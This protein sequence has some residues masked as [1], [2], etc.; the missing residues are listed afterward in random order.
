MKITIL[1]DNPNSWI[2]HYVARLKVILGEASH[3]FTTKGMKKGDI[4]FIL[5][6]ENIIPPEIL[7]LHKYNVVIHPSDLPKGRGWSPLAW[8]IIEGKND[9]VFT[10]FEATEK[11]DAGHVYM[12]KT[13]RLEGNELN[14]EIK[15]LQ[16]LMVINMV[17]EI[18]SHIPKAQPQTGVATYYDKRTKEHSLLDVN[19]SIAEQFNLLRVV[20]NERYPA[21]FEY[22]GRRYILS[23]RHE[24]L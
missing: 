16:G 18:V 14:E 6:C 21:Y 11:A 20:D 5:S 7:K 13:L 3:I 22:R 9:I 12:K 2:I 17:S 10:A 19:K 8:Q 1:T 4:L 15:H 24:P 23:I